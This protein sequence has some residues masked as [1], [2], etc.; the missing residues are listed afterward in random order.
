MLAKLLGAWAAKLVA[1][2]ESSELEGPS[3]LAAK[4]E[5]VEGI[6]A[7]AGALE[8]VH[9]TIHRCRTLG[10][11]SA[12]ELAAL[13]RPALYLQVEVAFSPLADLEGELT[14]TG[15][16][17]L[18][19]LPSPDTETL[20]ETQD[21]QALCRAAL[22]EADGALVV[23][24]ASKYEVPQWMG[25]LLREAFA[26]ETGGLRRDDA[27][28]VAN[29][30]D[31]LPEFFCKDGPKDVCK[32]VSQRQY[33]NHKDV[34]VSE[35][36][37][38]PISARL[39]LLAMY[40]REK[41]RE[42][43][44]AQL[45]ARFDRQPWFAQLCSLIFGIQ[46]MSK[47]QDLE[48]TKWR[49]SMRELHLMGQVTGPLATSVLKTAYV[50]MLPHSVER[51][52]LE[53]SLLV[54][55]FCSALHNLDG[56]SATINDLQAVPPDCQFQL[57]HG[58]GLK[59]VWVF[60]PLSAM[61]PPVKQPQWMVPH[62]RELYHAAIH[63]DWKSVRRLVQHGLRMDSKAAEQMLL[64]SASRDRWEPVRIIVEGGCDLSSTSGSRALLLAAQRGNWEAVQL[65]VERGADLTSDAALR[66]FIAAASANRVDTGLVR[67]RGAQ[68]RAEL[69]ALEAVRIHEAECSSGS[70]D[71][72]AK[73]LEHGL[74][75][76][77]W[78]G[79]KALVEAGTHGYLDVVEHLVRS[80]ADLR[81]FAGRQSLLAAAAKEHTDVMRFLVVSGVD[82]T[83]DVGDVVMQTAAARNDVHLLQFLLD[84]DVDFTRGVAPSKSLESAARCRSWEALH[85]LI[86]AKADVSGW[87]G[88]VALLA[89]AD[90]NR[91]ALLRVLEDA[92]VDLTSERSTITLAQA[93][94]CHRDRLERH[95]EEFTARSL[96]KNMDLVSHALDVHARQVE[97][98]T[99]AKNSDT[100][101]AALA[102]HLHM[103]GDVDKA[104]A[105]AD[106][107]LVAE[108]LSRHVRLL[109]EQSFQ[110]AFAL[111]GHLLQ[112]P[113]QG[114]AE[115]V[116]PQRE[117]ELGADIQIA[118]KALARQ[119]LQ[120]AAEEGGRDAAPAE[121]GDS[122][123]GCSGGCSSLLP[124]DGREVNG[125]E[126]TAEEGG[127]GIGGGTACDLE[128]PAVV[129]GGAGGASS[130]P[131]EECGPTTPTEDFISAARIALARHVLNFSTPPGAQSTHR[132]SRSRVDEGGPVS[133][134]EE[135]RET[136][137][138]AEMAAAKALAEHL[139]QL[140]QDTQLTSKALARHLLSFPESAGL[141]SALSDEPPGPPPCSPHGQAETWQREASEDVA[142]ALARHLMTLEEGQLPEESKAPGPPPCSPH[143]RTW[144]RDASEEVAAALA[145]HL[146]ALE[147]GKLPEESPASQ[148]ACV[149]SNPSVEITTVARALAH[150]VLNMEEESGAQTCDPDTVAVARALARHALG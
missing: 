136:D 55:S 107:P 135:L 101:A 35:D 65:L 118:A 33:R 42:P 20:W 37:V 82:V 32:K 134:L 138:I 97:A 105:N 19:D 66:A 10:I 11:V 125:F 145:R 5:A 114:P 8:A 80:K 56:T 133:I 46:W 99:L 98:E 77:S 95:L 94:N 147:E 67:R 74:D 141:G 112:Q 68:Y 61:G 93:S 29:R 96:A 92:G 102:L 137:E 73:F 31:Q 84:K 72:V 15:L 34:I 87:S 64:L 140:H 139:L 131:T 4:G 45:V 24:D 100:V 109:E 128:V 50:K 81:S 149:S 14:D 51:V 103:Q 69:K 1:S 6:D 36:H 76:A 75:L 26:Q 111:A 86:L 21:A 88:Q 28:I 53:L 70:K 91:F 18:V 83:G 23:I 62:E 12:E 119:M 129:E 39:S 38:I 48:Q 60:A 144:Q 9:R 7:V 59:R 22:R 3:P 117:T 63:N 130:A 108:A 52:M 2:P 27:W 132:S 25:G 122:A 41:V 43:L 113:L 57:R 124:E 90:S 17:S 49:N 110:V 116:D 44:S 89:A 142:A 143:G 104:Q 148:D 150:Q 16:L 13:C 58:V 115:D 54:S 120:T 30:I 123:G 127:G 79:R 47:V 78:G 146:M 71:S 40:G 106:T 126:D 85:F 121:G